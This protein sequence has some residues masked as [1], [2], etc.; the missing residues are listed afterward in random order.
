[1][2]INE[3]QPETQ[4]E[5]STPKTETKADTFKRLANPRLKKA[6][7]AI[8]TLGNCS[9]PATYE[10]TPEQVAKMREVLTAKVDKV[11]QQFEDRI[12]VEDVAEE[13]L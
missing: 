2:D 1:M 9:N 8:D 5:T 7:K 3:P 11:M 13:I 10:Y 6:L 4:L 12:A